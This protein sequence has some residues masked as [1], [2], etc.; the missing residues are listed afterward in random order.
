MLLEKSSDCKAKIRAPRLVRFWFSGVEIFRGL[1]MI[2]PC[3]SPCCISFAGLIQVLS[4]LV[5]L[6]RVFRNN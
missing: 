4:A 2:F 6:S 3:S 1:N 5:Q